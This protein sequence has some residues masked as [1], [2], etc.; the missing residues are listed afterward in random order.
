MMLGI[1][2]GT[3]IDELKQAV[4]YS[5]QDEEKKLFNCLNLALQDIAASFSCHLLRRTMTITAGQWMPSDIA[6][7]DAIYDSEYRYAPRDRGQRNISGD[8]RRKFYISEICTTPLIYRRGISINKGTTSFTVE[9]PALDSAYIGEYIRFA[10]LLGFYKLASTTTIDST[11]M[12]DNLINEWFQ[13]RP[14]GTPKL[15]ICDE[16]GTDLTAS[17]TMDYWVLPKPL[18]D[19]SQTIPLPSSEYLYLKT[20]ARLLRFKENEGKVQS[21]SRDLQAA[22]EDMLSKNV[23]YVCP[24]FPEDSSGNAQGWGVETYE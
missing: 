24:E 2:C 7:I 15:G 22:K 8:N 13:V 17:V 14:E 5:S 16:E 21:Y 4:D 11:F 12:G 1:P 23:R 3:V 19:R 10:G 9:S 18:T 6:G 20:L